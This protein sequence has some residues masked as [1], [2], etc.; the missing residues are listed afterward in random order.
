MTFKH[1]LSK[2]APIKYKYIKSLFEIFKKLDK[3]YFERVVVPNDK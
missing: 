3:V 1:Y 2:P